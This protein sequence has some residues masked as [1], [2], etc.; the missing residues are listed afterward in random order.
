MSIAPQGRVTTLSP[1]KVEGARTLSQLT[2]ID[3]CSNCLGLTLTLLGAKVYEPQGG[4]REILHGD[5]Y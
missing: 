3:C 2:V 5:Q 1:V 4:V